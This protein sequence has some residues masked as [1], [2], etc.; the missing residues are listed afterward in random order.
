MSPLPPLAVRSATS[1][2]DKYTYA[3]A[4]AVTG[5][6][7]IYGSTLGGT[8]VAITGS[9]FTGATAVTFGSTAVTSFAVISSTS[10]TATSPAGSAGTVDVTVTT[11]GGASATSA[12]DQFTYIPPPNPN[13]TGTPL[14]GTTPLTVQFTDTSTGTRLRG[15]GHLEIVRPCPRSK[16]HH[17]SIR[18]QE[19][20]PSC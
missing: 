18:A 20:I 19:P 12:A 1:S 17:T 10:I 14:T 9:G 8:S 5:I 7:P 6:L 15:H 4:P 11:P 2:V 3:T 16:I 13:F